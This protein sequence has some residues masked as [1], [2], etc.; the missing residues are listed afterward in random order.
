MEKINTTTTVLKTWCSF[1]SGR[2]IDIF[3]PQVY[4][5]IDF[6]TEVFESCVGYTSICMTRATLN[7][8]VTVDCF[9]D[10]SEYPLMK[11]FIKG[12]FNIKPPKP[13]YSYTRDIIKVLAHID[14]LGKYNELANKNLFQKLLILLLLTS[15]SRINTV[16]RLSINQMQINGESCT[17]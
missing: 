17:Y 4:E 13:R 7:N 14:D 12:V 6:L 15:G 1:C 10:I 9:P 5:V 3:H 16:M 8:I 2:K 11:R